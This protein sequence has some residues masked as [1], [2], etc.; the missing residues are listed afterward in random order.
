MKRGMAELFV[1]IVVS[2]LTGAGAARLRNGNQSQNLAAQGVGNVS[3]H[4][5]TWQPPCQCM[6]NNP[7]WT[8]PAR[9]IPKCIFIDL[10]AA[11]GN[12]FQKF[13]QNG[14]GPVANCPSGQ[15]ESY[16]VEANPQFTNQLQ[17]VA[18]QSAQPVHV[19][20]GTAAFTCEGQTSFY[21]DT[22]PTHNHWGSSMSASAPDAI[23]SGQQKVT[24]P[25]MNVIRLI[26]ENTLPSDW[27]ILKVDIEGAEFDLVPCLAQFQQASLIDRMF[28]EEHT[29]FDT[30]SATT[31]AQM[32]AAKA[33]LRAMNVD[34]PAYF[35]NTL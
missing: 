35:T 1:W 33:Q 11:D 20:G 2:L 13:L 16:L 12:T 31:P 30:G 34:I 26:A 5:R 6:A 15:W 17:A 22:D 9:T 32:E 21:I 14:Y 23:K 7:Q 25:T 27:V 29:W 4:A 19:L 10:G 24:V 8:K 3:F 18:A 28:L